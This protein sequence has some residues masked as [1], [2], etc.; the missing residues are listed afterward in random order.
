MQH[1]KIKKLENYKLQNVISG[2]IS[3]QKFVT[4]PTFVQN[5]VS[6]VQESFSITVKNVVFLPQA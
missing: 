1:Y 2:A 4:V 5:F 6:F 3:E